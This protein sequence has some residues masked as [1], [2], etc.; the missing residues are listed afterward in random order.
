MICRICA[1]D[2]DWI[3]EM[4]LD[5]ENKY[6]FYGN[7]TLYDIWLLLMDMESTNYWLTGNWIWNDY[8]H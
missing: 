1:N 5:F 3:K 2:L 8:G 4:N 7:W 6:G